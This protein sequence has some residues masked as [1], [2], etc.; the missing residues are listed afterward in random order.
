[1]L[2]AGFDHPQRGHNHSVACLSALQ[3]KDLLV[4]CPGLRYR[5]RPCLGCAAKLIA[6]VSACDAVQHGPVNTS[7]A[8]A[9]DEACAHFFCGLGSFGWQSPLAEYTI[10]YIPYAEQAA[11]SSRDAGFVPYTS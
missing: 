11:P 10:D 2:L 6:G 7:T 1:M 4:V 9:S 8:E 5:G 3:A